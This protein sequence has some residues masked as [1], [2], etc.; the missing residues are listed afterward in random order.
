[1]RFWFCALLGLYFFPTIW[2][3][4]LSE[5]CA[6]QLMETLDMK[7]H[8]TAKKLSL[9]PDFEVGAEVALRNDLL[10]LLAS[11]RKF[12]WQ[13]FADPLLKRQFEILLRDLKYPEISMKFRRHTYILR[14]V[15]KQ[16]FTCDRSRPN[17]CKLIS[18]IRH[19]KPIITNS[20]DP[21]EIKWY[22][23]EWR[24]HLPDE[25]K[26]A[27]NFYVDYYLNLSMEASARPSAI[28]Y[29]RY[30]NPNF[31]ENLEE[32][33][34]T[35]EPLYR[36]LHGHL[37]EALRMKYGPEVIPPSG[38]IPHHFLEQALYQS[39]KKES[40]LENPYPHKKMPNLLP[41]LRGKRWKPMD[42]IEMSG[43]FFESMGFPAFSE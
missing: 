19:I 8:Q 24:N 26:N 14:T 23:R 39:W 17:K 20:N 28:W 13:N 35:I 38:L 40:I 21:D 42:L 36:E 11:M 25:I 3:E 12:D 6:Q 4:C 7:Y 27:L 9:Y 31:L 30:D 5:S 37:R 15:G 1:M 2:A 10:P 18:Y 43:G 33:M 29:E 32:Y 41:E 22:W 16:K 34:K